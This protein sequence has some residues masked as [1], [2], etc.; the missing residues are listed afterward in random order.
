[1]GTFAEDVQLHAR[2]GYPEFSMVAKEELNLHAFLQRF[3]PEQ[4]HQGV[5]FP[6][7]GPS[8]IL[9]MKLNGLNWCSLHDL[10][11]RELSTHHFYVRTADYKEIA[12]V[13]QLQLTSV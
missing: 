4:L 5:F 13:Y 7:P 6:F 8:V 2:R 11:S 1:M 9:S 12:E 10:T 3:S